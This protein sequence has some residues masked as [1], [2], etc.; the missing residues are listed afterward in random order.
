MRIQETVSASHSVPVISRAPGS[1]FEQ[2][3]SATIVT[4]AV[5]ALPFRGVRRKFARCSLLLILLLAPGCEMG[6][7]WFSMSSDS[8]MPWFGFDLTFPRR[9]SQVGPQELDP[10]SKANRPTRRPVSNRNQAGKSF[11]KELHLPTIPAFFEDKSVEELSFTG[12][13]STFS[14]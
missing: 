2:E 10:E 1:A 6:R 4:T 13:E 8:P 3:N 12:P 9:T 14:R 11:S 7:S 5:K